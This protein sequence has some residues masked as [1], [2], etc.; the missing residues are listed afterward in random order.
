VATGLYPPESGGPATYTRLLEEKLPGRGI[1]VHALPFRVVRHLP[2]GIRHIVYFGKCFLGARQVD[3]IYAQDTVSVG[4]PAACAAWI[5]RKPFIVR[6]PG[7]YAW[8]QGIQR[9][10]VVES[11]DDFQP[12][13]Y[14]IRVG[15]LRAAQ[16]F[17]LRR[18]AR[19]ITP[20]EYLKRI[21]IGWGIPE[22]HVE[23]IY[24]GV[25]ISETPILPT[26]R[27][28]GFFIVTAARLVPWKGIDELID[29]IT[30]EKTWS[31]AIVGDGP[32]R[33]AL[34]RRAQHG[35][36]GRVR[37]LGRL[38][39]A[40]TLGWIEKADAFVLNSSYEGLSHTIIEAMWLG[41][42]IVATNVGGNPE[43]LRDGVDGVLVPPYDTDALRAALIHLAD[44]T[45][46]AQSLGRSARIHAEQFSIEK[47]LDALCLLL[48]TL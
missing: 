44:N 24:N 10:D 17:T 40:E 18:A 21:V 39:H 14:G 6:V 45:S 5:A 22:A 48:Q 47:T 3:V 32:E 36:E 23:V 35:A 33:R 29:L 13:S 2:P 20:S 38:S 16:R 25:D 42:P 11:L 1:E 27:P 30:M 8:E 31:L 15:L 4:F 19:V 7:D 12:R 43:T 46:F 37:F 9:F 26:E 34:E 41:R 28:R